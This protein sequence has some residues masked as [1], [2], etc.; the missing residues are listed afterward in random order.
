[1]EVFGALPDAVEEMGVGPEHVEFFFEGAFALFF[2]EEP[3][4][5]EDAAADHG[6]VELVV[7][8]FFTGFMN[9]FNVAV[10]DDGDVGGELVA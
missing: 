2:Q 3:G 1:M 9:G 5:V 10:A 4:V 8:A 6:A 7:G